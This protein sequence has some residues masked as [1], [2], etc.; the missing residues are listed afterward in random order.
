[1]PFFA[2]GC[3]PQRLE[4]ARSF[5]ADP[6]H[7]APGTETTLAKVADQVNDCAGLRGREAAVVSEFLGRAGGS[8]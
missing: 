8:R 3:E 1:M 2:S 5:F 6:A 4:K 7:R